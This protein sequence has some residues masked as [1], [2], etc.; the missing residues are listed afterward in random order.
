MEKLTGWKLRDKVNEI[1]DSNIKE[2]PWEGLDVNKEG[3]RQAIIDLV[4][5]QQCKEENDA[6]TDN[7]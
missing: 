4:Q 7:N 6:A 5:S 2:V 1:L 3:L